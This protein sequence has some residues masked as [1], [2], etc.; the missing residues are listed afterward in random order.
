MA[1]KKKE[2][3]LLRYAELFDDKLVTVS[4]HAQKKFRNNIVLADDIGK[5]S[6][7][8]ILGQ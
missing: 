3:H 2:L 6:E 8:Y 4:A 7:K 1:E 5:Y